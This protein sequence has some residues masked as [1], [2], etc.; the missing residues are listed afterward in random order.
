MVLVLGNCRIRSDHQHGNLMG[1]QQWEMGKE[2][3]RSLLRLVQV[4][5]EHP[6]TRPV[7]CRCMEVG[8]GQVLRP[9]Q[10]PKSKPKP[11]L[12]QVTWYNSWRPAQPNNVTSTSTSTSTQYLAGLGIDPSLQAPS[13]QASKQALPAIC[14][15]ICHL[16]RNKRDQKITQARA[17]AATQRLDSLLSL[18]CLLAGTESAL[19]PAHPI[20]SYLWL[21]IQAFE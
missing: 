7:P 8:P 12:Q 11:H 20:L 1:E 15:P 13:F 21:K 17:Q 9:V 16:S 14:H 4:A 2:K 18:L 5:H 10:D 6:C 19:G 3:G